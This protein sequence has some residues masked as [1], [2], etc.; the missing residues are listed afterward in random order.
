METLD[1]ILLLIK[2]LLP[3]KFYK[4]PDR[5]VIKV[6]TRPSQIPKM[7]LFSKTNFLMLTITT[8]SFI[9]GFWQDSEYAFKSVYEAIIDLVIIVNLSIYCVLKSMWHNSI[10]SMTFVNGKKYI[11]EK[12]FKLIICTLFEVF[13]A[14]NFETIAKFSNIFRITKTL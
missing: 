7:E 8:N 5:T 13:S 4:R 3:T 12:Y 9:L 14:I 2:T 1:E 10:I 6:H 11:R